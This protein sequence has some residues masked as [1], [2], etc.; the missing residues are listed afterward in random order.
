MENNLKKLEKE[1]LNNGFVRLN[2][3]KKYIYKYVS[4]KK[5]IQKKFKFQFK[6]NN[7]EDFH[8]N[9]S[10]KDINKIRMDII[11][12]I[13][14]I[15]QLKNDIYLS[16]QPFIDSLLGPDIIIQK[17]INLGIQMPEDKSRALFHKDTPLS[18]YHEIVL[19]IPLVDCKK[20]M[21]MLMIDR[22]D[23]NE[24]EEL[25]NGKKKDRFNK[26]VNKKGKLKEINFGQALI[27][28]TNN[29]HYIP[30]NKTS[31]TRWAIN[32]RL[33]N[34]FSPYG[35]RNL[36]DYYELLKISPLSKMYYN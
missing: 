14:S 18:S 29:Y 26:F 11:K 15:D 13:N 7:F 10:T 6:D 22:K 33:K 30:I 28:N 8:K 35:E 24:A 23:Q 12:Y 17:S 31:K 3:Q 20:S 19:W 1:F 9:V 16:L 36:L 25:L 32:I 4:L 5:K 27:F 34:L 21:C 2:L